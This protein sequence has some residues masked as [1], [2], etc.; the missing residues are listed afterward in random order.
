MSRRSILTHKTMDETALQF[1]AILVTVAG[2]L[3]WLLRQVII[4]FIKSSTEKSEYIEKLVAANQ[5]NT[6]NFVNTINHQRTLDREMQAKADKT[7]EK[8]TVEI[9]NTNKTT[10]RLIEFL[11]KP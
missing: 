5:V 7:L 10:N 4:Y 8:L 11:K 3:G 1:V 6:E 9:A 2:L